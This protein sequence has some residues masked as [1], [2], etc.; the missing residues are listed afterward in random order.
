MYRVLCVLRSGNFVAR[1]RL[2]ATYA[3]SAGLMLMALAA[4]R[5]RGGGTANHAEPPAEVL[6]APAAIDVAPAPLAALPASLLG[7]VPLPLYHPD[8]AHPWNRLHHALFVHPGKVARA[9]CQS[10][11]QP[12]TAEAERERT[13]TGCSDRIVPLDPWPTLIEGPAGY[14]DEPSLFASPDVQHLAEEGRLARLLALIAAAQAQAAEAKTQPLSAL[15]FQS[16]LWERFDTLDAAAR[17]LGAQ[18]P[19]ADPATGATLGAG[20][21][22]A[23]LL[24]LRDALGALIRAV[25]LPAATIAALPSN[26][27]KLA[28]A[29][30][31]LLAGFPGPDWQEVITRAR[32]L[33]EPM[34]STE[35]EYT[36]HAATAGFRAVFRRYVAVPAASGGPEWLRRTLLAEPAAPKLPPGTR[37]LI[38]QVPLAISREGQLVPWNRTNLIELRTALAL[39][40]TLPESGL[41]GAQPTRLSDLP[42][43]VLEGRRDWLRQADPPLAGLQRLAGDALFPL[44]GTCMPQPFSW[45]PMRAV[46][47]TCHG[48]SGDILLGAMTH[49]PQRTRLLTSVERPTSLVRDEKL[50]SPDWLALRRGF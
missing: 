22:R 25:A 45:N 38:L 40:A 11:S 24:Y 7:A 30:P 10:A 9:T 33:P 1:S 20:R 41:E 18:G 19:S 3:L 35:Q 15:L 21:Q 12:R 28:S 2:W 6:V 48:R 27:P 8:P 5:P 32:K 16:D 37:F 4:C 42:F 13:A 46:C 36:R 26:W 23:R 47:M 50:R 39:P 44:G 17:K 34:P 31:T 43:E 29:Y 14:G 49:G